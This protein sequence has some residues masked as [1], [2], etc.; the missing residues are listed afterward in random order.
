MPDVPSFRAGEPRLLARR[1]PPCKAARRR[2]RRPRLGPGRSRRRTR[3][4]D[5]RTG[6]GP[7]DT[8]QMAAGGSATSWPVA[9]TAMR[10]AG[11]GSCRTSKRCFRRQCPA[12]G[13]AP[14]CVRARRATRVDG[15]KPSPPSGL[16]CPVDDVA[17]R[18]VL[19]GHR[20]GDRWRR[21]AILPSDREAIEEDLGGRARLRRRACPGLRSQTRAP[22]S[23]GGGVEKDRY[24][25]LE[26]R[27][28]PIRRRR[29]SRPPRPSKRSCPDAGEAL[30]ASRTPRST[31]ARR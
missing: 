29:S 28:T 4:P 23:G 18:R 31:P 24:V 1:I 25:L 26:P 16:S 30:T 20:R 11:T 7:Q 19:L 17:G 13:D 10:R 8:D 27:S 12:R 6:D 14:A 15:S 9:I 3:Y 21:G 5:A 22:T 2:K